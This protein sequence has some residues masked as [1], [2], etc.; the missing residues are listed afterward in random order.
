[1]NDTPDY[2]IKK[3]FEIIMSKPLRERILMTFDMIEF[4]RKCVENRIRSMNP[5]ISDIDLK[6][7]VFNIF[8]EDLPEK[9]KKGVAEMMQHAAETTMHIKRKNPF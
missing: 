7:T 2:I 8:Y 1:M 6:I 4:A 3:Q 5:A 9:T